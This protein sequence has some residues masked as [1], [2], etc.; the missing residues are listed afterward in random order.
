MKEKAKKVLSLKNKLSLEFI[1][2]NIWK[3]QQKQDVKKAETGLKYHKY[4][5]DEVEKSFETSLSNGLNKSHAKDLLVKNGKNKITQ[6]RQNPVLKIIGYFFSGFC[7]L[8]WI[9]AIICILA[10]KPIGDPSDPTN[11]GL[12]VLL[13]VVI[14]LQAAFTA[15][16]DWSSG[17][18]MKSIKN[19][20]PSTATVIREGK[21]EKIPVEEVVVGDL[22]LLQYGQ[23]VPADVRIIE[24][25]DLQFDKS[26]LTGESEAIDGTVE[27]TDESYVESKNIGYMTTLITNGRGKGIVVD[28]GNKTLMGKIA[29]LTSDTSKKSTTLQKELRRFVLIIGTAALIMAVIVI[30]VWA[31]WLR[32][33]HKDYINVP[34]IMVN[35]ISVMIAF[36]P[37]GLPVCVTL[38][39]LIIAKKMAKNRVLVKNLPVIETLSCVNV[40]ASD[41]TGTLTQNKMFVANANAGSRYLKLDEMNI[42]AN[43]ENNSCKQLIAISGLCNNAKFD[44]QSKTAPVKHRKADGDAT[45]IALLRFYA[46]HQEVLKLEDKYQIIEDIPFNSKNKWMAK[47]I[48]PKDIQYNTE[49]MIDAEKPESDIILLKGA[50]EYLL[51]KSKFI[52]D[53][54]G[55]KADFDENKMDQIKRIQNAWCLNGQRVLILCKKYFEMG[56]DNVDHTNPSFDLEGYIQQ[57]NDFIIVG[58]VGIIDPPREGISDVIS[59]LRTAGI[60]LFMVTGD[61]AL[62]ASAIALQIGI[63]TNQDYDEIENLRNDDPIES[64]ELSG[65]LLLSGTDIEKLNKDDWRKITKYKEIVFA[66]TTPEQKLKIVKEFQ[67]DGFIVGVT[68]DGVNDAPALKSADIGIAMGS[69]SEVAMEASQLVLLDSNFSSILIAIRNGRLVFKNLRKVIL[70]L[71]PG[72]CFAELIPVLMS[73]FLGVPQ[74]ISS[75][76]MLII[77]LFTDICPSLSLMMEKEESDLLNQPPR[78]KK[79]HL[80]D[81]KFMLQAYAFLGIMIVF[82]SQFMFFLY[83]YTRADLGPSDIFFSFGNW[84]KFR[85]NKTFIDHLN[86]TNLTDISNQTITNQPFYRNG[87]TIQEHYYRGQTVTF[88]AII[89]LQLFGNL[90]S[91]RTHINS[92]FMQL[93]WKKATKNMWLFP[94]QIVSIII[95]I[96]VVFIP[97]INDLFNSRP[98]PVHF[99]FIPIGFALLIF[100]MDELRKLFVRRKILC[101][102]KIGW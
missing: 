70:Y 88:I 52:L 16:Q 28:T 10:W 90:Y 51:K 66:R 98:V 81:Y 61:Y 53:A 38:S 33:K 56:N 58:L 9:A 23:K 75:F 4:S 39:L 43:I 1:K 32:V 54:D 65:S 83:M 20:M 15:F 12:G 82:S 101:F 72:G 8:I 2:D 3:K 11:L 31:S 27:C 97:P 78:S 93:P 19:M 77:S 71:L 48:K 17:R 99:F 60:R 63:F 87:Y 102:P 57:S 29:G 69:G 89:I 94:A 100:L 41:K 50:P 21:E 67:Q 85:P 37:E 44:E 5:L 59:K 79:D 45:D 76:Q 55:S 49:L 36:I 22:V 18:V 64:D 73:I 14:V 84:E 86:H 47:W 34:S 30:V 6:N 68:G 7:I 96:L 40:I 74:N 92:F 26:M 13:I 95:M 25:H 46:E 42:E 91:T 24:S 80:I 62:T 35:T